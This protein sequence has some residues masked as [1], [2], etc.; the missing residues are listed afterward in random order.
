VPA[1]RTGMSND[2][3]K[4]IVLAFTTLDGVVEDPDGS[5]G[6]PFG[7]WGFRHG[8]QAFAGDK[9]RLGPI[10]DTGALLFGRATWELFAQRWPTRTDDFANAMNRIP[11][12]VASRTLDSVDGWSNSTLLHGDLTDAIE[13][14]RDERDV[15]VV[16]STSIVRQLD[17]RGLVDEYR[18]AVFP[19]VL[20]AGEG[21]F[22]GGPSAELRI[23]SADVSAPTV[24]LRYEVQRA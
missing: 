13:R 15:L 17:A 11:K 1:V 10:L 2:T 9:F 4:I 8:P 20:G 7:G 5:W 16:G 24:L 19:T 12:Y 23:V 3:N 14:L 22:D 18:L 6:T 21:L